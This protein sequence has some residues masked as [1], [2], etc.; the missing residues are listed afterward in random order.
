[1]N[2]PLNRQMIPRNE[3]STRIFTDPVSRLDCGILFII[4][5]ERERNWVLCT[6][7]KVKKNLRTKCWTYLERRVSER[8]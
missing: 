5:R 7:K 1:M 4:N 2:L 3:I 8:G 6:E